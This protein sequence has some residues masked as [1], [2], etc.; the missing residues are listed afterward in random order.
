MR[1]LRENWCFGYLVFWWGW[2][3]FFFVLSWGCFL[4]FFWDRICV[5]LWVCCISGCFDDFCV[6]VLLC[7]FLFFMNGVGVYIICFF[8]NGRCIMER[9]LFNSFNEWY[10]YIICYDGREGLI[11]VLYRGWGSV[12]FMLWRIG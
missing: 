7:F 2:G 5:C 12:W 9:L 11:N 10:C 4:V 8:E 6:W 1:L 3:I